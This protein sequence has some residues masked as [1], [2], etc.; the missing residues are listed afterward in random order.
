MTVRETL[1]LQGRLYA[2]HGET[3]R[4]RVDR[5][6][7]TTGLSDRAGHLVRTLSGGMKRRLELGRA[8]LP[9][10]ELLLLDEP[11]T[12]LDPDSQQTLWEHLIDINR[13]GAT[14]L[15][16]TNNVSEA[17]AH[18]DTVAFIHRGRVVAQG[19]PAGLKD[20][21][22]RDGVW[23]EAGFSDSVIQQV[24]GWPDVGKL[25]WA[26]PVLHATVD[27]AA[28][29]VPRLFQTA[30]EHITS[31]RLR[32]ATLEDAYFDIVGTRL[33]NGAERA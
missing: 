8:L 23:V 26:P 10:P 2:M 13:D 24:S 20:G 1:N 14:I 7:H 6:L 33:S 28:A 31:V 17:D 22:K 21:L 16:A 11:T 30:G 18:C 27:S 5:V 9:S 15:V 3:L 32:E 12:G 4:Q 19:S 29:F 25:T